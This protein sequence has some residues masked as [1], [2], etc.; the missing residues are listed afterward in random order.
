M[1]HQPKK[2]WQTPKL[3]VLARVR[4]EER[5]LKNCK[6]LWVPG[7]PQWPGVMC[8]VTSAGKCDTIVKS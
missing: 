5:V 4:A 3:R 2:D 1:G 7:G 6:T 8:G